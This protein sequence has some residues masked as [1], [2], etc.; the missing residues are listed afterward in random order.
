MPNLSTLG[1]G[2]GKAYRGAERYFDKN[3]LRIFLVTIAASI[4]LVAIA[5]CILVTIRSGDGGVLFRRFTGT[6][7]TQVYREGLHLIWPWDTMYIYDTRVQTEERVVNLLTKDGLPVKLTVVVR[8]RPDF[9]MLPQL[10]RVV[11]PNYLE[12]VVMPATTAALRRL[13]GTHEPI[14]IYTTKRGQLKNMVLEAL[15]ENARL[16]IT[17]DAVLVVSVQLP[18]PVRQAIED[19][20]I[21]DQKQLAYD[22]RLKLEEKEAIRKRI[23]AAGIRD[24]NAAVQETL[25]PDLL[26]WRGIEATKELAMSP[27]SKTV[28]IG[29][30]NNGLPLILGNADGPVQPPP[31]AHD[32]LSMETASSHPAAPSA[33][34]RTNQ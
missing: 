34:R 9:R 30:G 29:S 33:G 8:Y 25:T 17:I 18:E 14:E 31:A 20:L 3:Q 6:D 21:W 7:M 11:G 2:A 16:F 4:F 32:K 12:T 10:H 19:K 28:V 23:E 24:Y 15:E 5:P 1:A 22:Y 13:I 26:R 27:N